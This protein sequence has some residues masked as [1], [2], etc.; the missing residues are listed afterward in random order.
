[1]NVLGERASIAFLAISL[2]SLIVATR[3]SIAQDAGA[4]GPGRSR[5]PEDPGSVKT[6]D[7][8]RTE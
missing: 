1:M 3:L 5:A 8:W 6:P 4:I 7:E 2:F